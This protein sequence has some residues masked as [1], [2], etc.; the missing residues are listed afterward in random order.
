[1]ETPADERTKVLAAQVRSLVADHLS[2]VCF[3]SDHAPFLD[4]IERLAALITFW[5]ARINLT[6]KPGDSRELAFHI[7]D[8]LMPIIFADREEFLR[9]AFRADSHVL[10]LGSGTGFP[11]L[12]LALASPANFT[13]TESR[14]KRASFLTIAA[15]EMGLKNVEVNSRRVSARW[16]TTTKAEVWFDAVVARAFATAPAFHSVAASALKPGGI[17][18]LY[19]NPGQDLALLTA[20]KN[21]LHEFRPVAYT[22]PRDGHVVERILGLWRRR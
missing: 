10:D 19:A 5:G 22:I 9:H 8:S 20:E 15:G 4:R 16:T 12:V 14:R 17:A 6:A 3:A 11:G 1:M 18:I 21:G 13:L 7:I 2:A